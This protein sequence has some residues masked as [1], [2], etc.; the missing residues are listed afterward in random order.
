ME[1]ARRFLSLCSLCLWPIAVVAAEDAVE[2]PT[3]LQKK[4]ATETF[5]RQGLPVGISRSLASQFFINSKDR[6]NLVEEMM[7]EWNQVGRQ[8][9]GPGVQFFQVP[10]P[11][12]P[13]IEHQSASHYLL[14]EVMGIYLHSKW[15][16]SWPKN[17][18]AITRY[19]ALPR[20]FYGPHIWYE[21]QHA[22]II[23]N[24]RFF[25]FRIHTHE[26]YHDGLP[27]YDLRTTILHELGHF[28]GLPHLKN[29]RHSVMFE[30]FGP[31]EDKHWPSIA[32]AALLKNL[33]SP[34]NALEFAFAP[35][36]PGTP[37][38]SYTGLYGRMELSADGQCRHYQN[39]RFVEQHTLDIDA[40]LPRR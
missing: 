23:L 1:S 40:F 22:D 33:Y 39:G 4:W 5:S 26:F 7:Q 28:L 32:D 31:K 13:N 36:T 3:V 10:A 37:I 16:S 6:P 8:V 20:D 27:R 21:I 15:P 9:F 18:L 38:L 12:V 2:R 25:R 17:A 19:F 30:K 11:I 24:H 29:S 34:R 35:Q 14:D